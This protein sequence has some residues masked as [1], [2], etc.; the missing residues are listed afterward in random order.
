MYIIY[1]I[2][3]YLYILI[4]TERSDNFSSHEN[5]DENHKMVFETSKYCSDRSV[6]INFT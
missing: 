3:T 4:Y 2:Y 1:I 6:Y 5:F